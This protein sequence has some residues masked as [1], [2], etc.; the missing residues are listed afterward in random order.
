M[1]PAE[2]RNARSRLGMSQRA[3][4]KYLGIPQATISR[5]EMGRHKI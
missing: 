5:W 4:A 3:L 2:L 1:T